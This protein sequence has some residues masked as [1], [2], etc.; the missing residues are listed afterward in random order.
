M[1]MNKVT[2][3]KTLA[4]ARKVEA[5]GSEFI[6]REERWIPILAREERRPFYLWKHTHPW[7]ALGGSTEARREHQRQR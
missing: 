7:A 1:E 6:S 2:T 3:D 4:S 5:D